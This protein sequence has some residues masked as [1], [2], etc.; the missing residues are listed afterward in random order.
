MKLLFESYSIYHLVIASQRVKTSLQR[1]TLII[2]QSG[3]RQQIHELSSKG[4]PRTKMK[5]LKEVKVCCPGDLDKEPF[6]FLEHRVLHHQT[7]I[8]VV[9]HRFSFSHRR[10]AAKCLLRHSN[11]KEI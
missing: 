8:R 1:E 7:P 11:L 3:L 6:L 2:L 10:L 5:C 4:T 9:L